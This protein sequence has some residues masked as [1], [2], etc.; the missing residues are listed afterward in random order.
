MTRDN[1]WWAESGDWRVCVDG[2][3]SAIR[4]VDSGG[5]QLEEMKRQTAATVK[6]YSRTRMKTALLKFWGQEVLKPYTW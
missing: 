2:I 1:G 4:M 6:T 3:A 5:G